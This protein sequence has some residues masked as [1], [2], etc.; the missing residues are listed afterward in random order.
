MD[1]LSVWLLSAQGA[2]DG[3]SRPKGLPSGSQELGDNSVDLVLFFF[4]L[5]SDGLP[6]YGVFMAQGAGARRSS[7]SHSVRVR[8]SGV[9]RGDGCKKMDE[10]TDRECQVMGGLG[11]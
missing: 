6:Y 4:F 8:L 5:A 3:A 9:V 11:G 1:F 10:A 7:S 2:I